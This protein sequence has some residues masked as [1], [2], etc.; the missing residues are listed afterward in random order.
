MFLFNKGNQQK[1]LVYLE[2]KLVDFIKHKRQ[3][4]LILKT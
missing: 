3:K 4:P 2:K 1:H